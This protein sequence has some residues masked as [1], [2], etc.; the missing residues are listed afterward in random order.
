MNLKAVKRLTRT[1]YVDTIYECR[2]CGEHM[3][4]PI[5]GHEC[6]TAPLPRIGA[7]VSLLRALKKTIGDEYRAPGCENETRPSM[8]VTIGWDS[9]TG[10]WSYQTGDNSYMGGAYLHPAWA[11]VGLYRSSPSYRLALD[12]RE[13]L[14]DS[15]YRV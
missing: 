13:Q 8:Q 4:T 5:G 14:Y 11:V 3:T 10:E 1:G 7:L 6:E 9:T 2:H 15:I 12:I